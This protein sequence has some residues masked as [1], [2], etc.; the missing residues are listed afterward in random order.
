MYYLDVESEST[1]ADVIDR[2]VANLRS[3]RSELRQ[4]CNSDIDSDVLFE[5]HIM[6]LLDV[7]GGTTFARHLSIAAH[8]FGIGR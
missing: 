6:M 3:A 5:R 4:S 1:P 7:R 8:Q 2:F